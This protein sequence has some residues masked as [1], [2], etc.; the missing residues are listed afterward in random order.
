MKKQIVFVLAV[1]VIVP[2]VAGTTILALAGGQ[3]RGESTTVR[4]VEIT[5]VL[6]NPDMGWCLYTHGWKSVED[7]TVNLTGDDAPI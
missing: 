2:A 3:T 7:N 4:P 5:D 6:H 1:V